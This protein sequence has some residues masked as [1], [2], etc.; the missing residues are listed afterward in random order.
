MVIAVE[1]MM[2]NKVLV[3]LVVQLYA[4]QGDNW[5]HPVCHSFCAMVELSE[6]SKKRQIFQRL[7]KDLPYEVEIPQ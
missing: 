6:S 1:K 7:L 3:D 2:K 5:I 4:T